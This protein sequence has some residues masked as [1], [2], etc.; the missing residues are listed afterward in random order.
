MYP[1]SKEV[2]RQYLQSYFFRR[3]SFQAYLAMLRSVS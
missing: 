3:I 1:N 2:F